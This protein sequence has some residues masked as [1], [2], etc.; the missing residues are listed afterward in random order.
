MRDER[1]TGSMLDRTSFAGAPPRSGRSRCPKTMSCP[2][3]QNGGSRTIA[4]MRCW[5]P[6]VWTAKSSPSRRIALGGSRPTPDVPSAVA[7]YT[8][9]CIIHPMK[10]L[11]F[12]GS[13]LADLCAFP[14]QARREAG[15]QLDKVQNGLEPNDWKPMTT[16][17][18]GVREIRIR[19]EDGL[20]RVVYVARLTG[21]IYVL[22]CFRKKTQRTA[23]A[24][25]DLASK[26]YR[27]LSQ[28]L[29][30]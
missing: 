27:D 26:R 8:E 20:F 3:F 25:L 23:K 14:P 7:E 10:K 17:G 16:I 28:E 2:W 22:H 9:Y 21:I 13:A 4:A 12:R 29:G 30:K 15:Y 18:Q 19:G 11:G 5:S 24:D 6:M 1:A